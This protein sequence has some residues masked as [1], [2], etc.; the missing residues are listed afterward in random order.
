[1][2]TGDVDLVTASPYHPQ[3]AV[4][5]VPAYRLFFSR[6]ASFLYRLLV[7]WNLY[8]WTA[9]FRAYRV[10][11]VRTVPFASNGFLAGTEILVNAIFAGYRAAE[12][13]TVLHSRVFGQSKAKI[14]RTVRAHLGYQASVLKRRFF[15]GQPAGTPALPPS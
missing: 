3:G 13:P 10:Q 12:Y 4:D 14:A 9:L 15:G 11:V 6:G 1:V 7:K 2:L 5:N 8:T